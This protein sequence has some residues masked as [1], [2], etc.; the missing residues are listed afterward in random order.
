LKEHAIQAR[1]DVCGWR[2]KIV[3]GSEVRTG[4]VPD[5]RDVEVKTTALSKGPMLAGQA[6][7]SRTLIGHGF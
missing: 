6:V 1:L 2:R 4:T 3:L 5:G 7:G